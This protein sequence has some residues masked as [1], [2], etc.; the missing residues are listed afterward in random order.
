VVAEFGGAILLECLGY[1]AESDRGGAYSYLKRHAE[2]EKRNL[3]GAC[4]ELLD[5]TCSSVAL[6]LETAEA[7]AGEVSGPA[8]PPA[9]PAEV[10]AFA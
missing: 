2:K 1:T 3:L 8:A 7:L 10:A 4:S 5:R 9:V 6:I